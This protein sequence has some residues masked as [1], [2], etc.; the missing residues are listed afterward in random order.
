MGS[1]LHA[2]GQQ[3]Q[4]D[5]GDAI[6]PFE[7]VAERARRGSVGVKQRQVASV[8]AGQCLLSAMPAKC[9]ACQVP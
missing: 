3:I 5:M 2:I 1:L 9:N 4:C 7:A 8:R 6:G